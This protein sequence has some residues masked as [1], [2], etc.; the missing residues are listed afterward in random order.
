MEK[1][2]CWVFLWL[3]WQV[4]ALTS[5]TSFR[6][7]R[8]CDTACRKVTSTT[9]VVGQIDSNWGCAHFQATITTAVSGVGCVSVVPGTGPC[10]SSCP[11]FASCV[12][13]RATSSG[14]WAGRRSGSPRGCSGNGCWLGCTYTLRKEK[15][16]KWPDGW[17]VHLWAL[18]RACSAR[19]GD[20]TKLWKAKPIFFFFFG[21]KEG[22]SFWVF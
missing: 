9:D 12:C 15:G 14:A 4:F 17:V 8:K 11:A 6:F 20:Q 1:E 2:C 3:V 21:T 16:R 18:W 5:N 13:A 22:L 10:Q 19:V 7:Y